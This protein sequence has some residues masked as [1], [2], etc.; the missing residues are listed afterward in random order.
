MPPRRAD[1]LVAVV[2][3]IAAA[4][5]VPWWWRP[6]DASTLVILGYLVIALLQSVLFYRRRAYPL[7]LLALVAGTLAVRAYLDQ[8]TTSAFTS[9][10]VAA[11]GVGAYS[12]WGRQYARW[13]GAA[14][15]IAALVVAWHEHG[16]RAGLP[17]AL[18]GAAFV[19]GD[20]VTARRN[21]SAS[22]IEAAHLAERARLARELHDVLAHQLSAITVQAGAAR[23]A[24]QTADGGDPT[25]Q[26]RP[27]EVLGTIER[28]AR[29]ALDELGHLLGA[30]RKD[31]AD[32]LT[33]RPTPG[34]R[35]LD[36]LLANA[37]ACGLAVDLA[38]TGPERTMAPGAQL[39]VY[40][41]VQEALTNAARHAPGAAACVELSYTPDTLRLDIVNGPAAKPAGVRSG[42]G[43]GLRGMR[44]RASIYGGRFDAT[45][46]DDGGFA[47]LAVLPYGRPPAEAA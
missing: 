39:A 6:H 35:D 1:A 46:R 3:L 7:P 18:L 24:L 5:N 42:T 27:A 8:D 38:V 11:Y 43:S 16:Y 10:L 40:R 21:E 44:E 25:G 22:A 33:R 26:V 13:T 15:L 29:G 20:A 30:L 41:I 19:A 12:R 28:L 32:D 2:L 17:L 37:R 23:L 36:E 4:P 47:V 34:L 31:P 45:A 9:V 14:L